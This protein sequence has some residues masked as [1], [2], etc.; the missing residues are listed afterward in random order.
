MQVDGLAAECRRVKRL[1]AAENFQSE[2]QF[3]RSLFLASTTAVPVAPICYAADLM[4][5]SS[6]GP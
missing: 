4:M 2:F 6:E 1:E 3:R 5:I